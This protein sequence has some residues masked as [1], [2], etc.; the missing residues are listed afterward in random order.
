M[1]LTHLKISTKIGIGFSAVT[2]AMIINALLIN[3]A[4]NKC[5]LL[6]EKIHTVYQPSESLLMDM[7]NELVNSLSL[8]KNWV[9][10]DK[11]S[12]TPDKKKLVS[13]HVRDFNETR[14][15]ILRLS[16]QWDETDQE[17]FKSDCLLITDTLFALHKF[18]MDKLSTISSYDD[19]DVLFQIIPMVSEN[20]EIVLKTKQAIESIG[21]LAKHQQGN[22]VNTSFHI[23]ETIFKLK[24][25]IIIT[26]F[27]LIIISL[28][29]TFITVNAIVKPI[30]YIKKTLLSMSK[31]VLPHEKIWEKNDEVGEM[32]KA[33]NELV[34]GLKG[35]SSFALEIGRG[36]YNSQ[37]K[38]LS[39]DDVLGNSLLRMRMI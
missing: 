31:G 38:P 16:D 9:Y 32:S 39:E 35:I 5:H 7:Q 36:N 8:I 23:N 20:G 12:E 3:N 27:V 34:S 2:L 11:I 4:L 17:K 6:N 22:I 30:N 15:Q 33:L 24:T 29:V 14:L 25:T 21:L 13:L 1:K 26:C 37:F 28:L 18:V 10:V 19:P